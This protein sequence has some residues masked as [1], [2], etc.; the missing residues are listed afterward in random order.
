MA[1]HEK[2]A[3]P[4]IQHYLK[5]FNTRLTPISNVSNDYNSALKYLSDWNILGIAISGDVN[6]EFGFKIDTFYLNIDAI[7]NLNIKEIHNEKDYLV[8]F[9]NIDLEGDFC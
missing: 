2:E 3:I 7:E 6:L 9:S 5:F 1:Q 8:L 4:Q